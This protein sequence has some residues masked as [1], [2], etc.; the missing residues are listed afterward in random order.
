MKPIF[1]FRLVLDLLAVSLLLAAL[2]Y[3]AFDNATHEVAGTA[4]FLLLIVHNIFNRRWYG[5]ITKGRREAR[6]LTTKAINLSLLIAI[7]I[8]LATSLVISQTVFSFLSLTSTFTIRQIH[9]LVAYTALLIVGLHIGLKWTML[10][11]LARSRFGIGT[12]S[13]A[14][15]YFLRAIAIAVAAGGAYA[16][17][18]QNV[19]AKLLMRQSFGFGNL[20]QPI[21]TFVLQH[22]AIVG[23][24][25][26]LTHYGLAV[27]RRREVREPT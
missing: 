2:A 11:G 19:G 21:S 18:D 5:A 8:L 1:L 6:S 14:R 20:E 13:R 10:M 26:S 7:L 24:F 23:L 17:F 27:S 12:G 22:I 9:T 4:M 3:Y 25:A 15:T 16:L